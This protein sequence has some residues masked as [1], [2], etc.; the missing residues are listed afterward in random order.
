ML[1]ITIPGEESFNDDTAQF[2]YGPTTVLDLEHSLV[3]LSKWEAKWETPFLTSSQ[4]TDEQML[5]YIRYMGVPQSLSPEQLKLLRPQDLER[6]N[7]YI[8]A[9]MTA[10][11]FSEDE[12]GR[13]SREII[14]SEVIYYWMVSYSIPIECESW[15]LNR[16]I[17]LIRVFN[18]KNAPEKKTPAHDLAAQRRRINEERK[19]KYNTTG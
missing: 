5:D 13:A 17:T 12:S 18:H 19:K 16:L 14:T 6:I 3:S 7:A 1:T 9:K 11:W 10:T 8:G 4:M 2:V 15:H